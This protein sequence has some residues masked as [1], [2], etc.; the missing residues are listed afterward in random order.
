MY[1]HNYYLDFLKSFKRFI[2]GVFPN[3]NHYQ[4]NYS[5]F[6]YLN[7]SLYQEHMKEFPICIINLN[8]MQVE[9]NSHVMRKLELTDLGFSNS[10]ILQHICN[11]LTLEESVLLEF[12]FVVLQMQVRI[13]FDNPG[14]IFNYMNIAQTFCPKNMMFY[15]YSYNAYINID[16]LTQH[17]GTDDELEN[18]YY[19]TINDTIS[20]YSIYNIEPIL[21]INGI[22]SSKNI[23]NKSQQDNFIELDLEVRIKVPNRIGSAT[24]N[25]QLINGIEIMVNMNN[26]TEDLPILIDLDNDIYSDV[27][28]RAQKI[29]LLSKDN[30]IINHE[31]DTY[32]LVLDNSL[33][34]EFKDKKLGIYLNEDCTA[35][36]NK[37]ILLEL[38]LYQELLESNQ[39]SQSTDGE[40]KLIIRILRDNPQDKEFLDNFIFGSPETGSMGMYTLII[41]K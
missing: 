32:K 21:K 11:N 35:P 36:E 33:E 7:Y 2:A 4:F 3:I 41:F 23:Q 39:V 6:T 13:N 18:V 1:M 34:D 27:R 22:T 14:D 12:K 38:G 40:N 17:W 20:R 19:R 28:S 8:D 30:F 31:T 26:N 15:E 37:S 24:I 10:N 16:E 29:Y 25:N 9:D 5:D